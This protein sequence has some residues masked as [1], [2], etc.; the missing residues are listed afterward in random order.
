MR[1][2]MTHNAPELLMLMG[3]QLLFAR[4]FQMTVR[5][6]NMVGAGKVAQ[7]FETLRQLRKPSQTTCTKASSPKRPHFIPKL[8]VDW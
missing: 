8:T 7:L 3:F 5:N 6:V 2:R 1:F 4:M